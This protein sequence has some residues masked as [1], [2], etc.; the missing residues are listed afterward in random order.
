[1]NPLVNFSNWLMT[2]L[3]SL[4]VA[5][6]AIYGIIILIQ[7]KILKGIIFIIIAAMAAVLIF[8][9]TTIPQKIST[10]I[11]SWFN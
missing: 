7:R 2:G 8:G 11:S 10:I 5:G 3:Q 4:F 1:M 6:C 9:G